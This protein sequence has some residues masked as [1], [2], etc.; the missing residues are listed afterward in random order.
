[1]QRI[2]AMVEPVIQQNVI[3]TFVAGLSDEVLNRSEGDLLTQEMISAYVAQMMQQTEADLQRYLN[4]AENYEG[5]RS[6]LIAEVS[7]IRTNLITMY[8]GL[9]DSLAIYTDTNDTR[10]NNL[11]ADVNRY[12]QLLSDITLDSTN[13]T[14]DNGEIRYGA[15][16]ILSQ[17]RQWDLDILAKLDTFKVSILSTLTTEINEVKNLIRS[18]EETLSILIAELGNTPL[19]KNLDQKLNSSLQNISTL[20]TQSANNAAAQAQALADM[21]AQVTQDTLTRIILVESDL[22]AEVDARANEIGVLEGYITESIA[23]VNTAIADNTAALGTLSTKITQ[24]TQERIAAITSLNDG[25]TSRMELLEQENAATLTALNNY[26]TSNDTALANVSSRIDA[27]V[28]AISGNASRVD[29]LDIRLTSNEGTAATALTK[30]ELALT[31]NTAQASQINSINLALNDKASVSALS[32]LE[33]EVT[34][35]DGRVTINANNITSLSSR[36]TTVEGTL[37]TKADNTALAALT[38]RMSTAEGKISTAA[39]DITQLQ[40][41]VTTINA[42]LETKVSSEAFNSLNSEVDVID[43]KVSSNTAAITSLNNSVNTINSELDNKAEATALNALTN[44]VTSING[45]VTAHS[46]SI[47]ELAGRVTSTEDTLETKADTSLLNSYYTK[48]ETEEVIAGSL[49][50]YKA[51]LVIGGVNQLYNTEGIRTTDGSSYLNYERSEALYNF[52]QDNLGKVIT[53]SFEAQANKAGLLNILASNISAHTFMGMVLIQDPTAW[54][55]YSVSVI[56]KANSNYNWPTLLSTLEFK[57]ITDGMV[58]QLRRVQLEAGTVATAWAPS[59]RDYQNV[60]EDL[61]TTTEANATAIESTNASVAVIN[62]TLTSISTS[63]DALEASLIQVDEKASTSIAN[64]ASAQQTANTA[65]SANAVTSDRVD[66]LEVSYNQVVQD[67]STK[68]SIVAVDAL[69]TRVTA[70]ENGLVSQGTSITQLQDQV[71]T[72]SS[73]VNTKASADA[74]S[75]LTTRVTSIE[76]ENTTQSNNIISLSNSLSTTN[77]NVATA[78]QAATDAMAAAN[79]KGKVIFGNTA[80]IAAERLPQNL[81]I[82][83]TSGTNT[84]KRWDGS[85]WIIVTDKAATDALAAANS[86][87]TQLTTK[88][89]ASALNTLTSSVNAIDTQVT[90]NSASITSLNNSVSSLNSA[91]PNKADSSAVTALTNTVNAQGDTLTAQGN[92]ITSLQ[93]SLTGV[94]NSL[95]T[96]ANAS[97]LSA[98]DTKVTGIE[99]NVSTLSTSLSTLTTEVDDNSATIAVQGSSINGILAEY[100]IKLD[101]NGRVAGVGLVNDGQSAAFGVNADF[102][103]GSAANKPFVVL[104]SGQTINGIA[105]PAGTWINTAFIA[106]ATIG[107]AKIQNASIDTAQIKDAAITSAKIVNVVADKI[108]VPSNVSSIDKLTSSNA[109]YTGTSLTNAAALYDGNW[110]VGSMVCSFGNGNQTFTGPET[111]YLQI[112]LKTAKRIRDINLWWACPDNRRHYYK[113]KVSMD[114]VT[115]GYLAGDSATWV[116]STLPVDLNGSFEKATSLETFNTASGMYFR[117]IRIYGNGN[118]VSTANQL[119]EVGISSENAGTIIDGNNIMTGSIAADRIKVNELSA[120]SANLG[121]MITIA[122]DNSK[123][124]MTGGKTEV[125]YPNGVVAVRL[126]VW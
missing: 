20:Y 57:G 66:N 7:N 70:N 27:N 5:D 22:N 55:R 17:A 122:A 1:M 110:K 52:Y 84:P 15:W 19:I 120:I 25:F 38:T 112:D 114:G 79:A 12:L 106:N 92:S 96:K 90:S 34:D 68:A 23:T 14:L 97:A 111:S 64:A 61:R 78:Q 88:A 31:E 117:Y 48:T 63:I 125:F 59:P 87:L 74:L 101:V 50:E 73:L 86:A 60:I 46:S 100:T 119:Y 104:A 30:A 72:V 28:T 40:S 35:I 77:S 56:V 62:G 118:T 58:P 113:V 76:G 33:A 89:D 54:I 82:D 32:A 102:Y 124:I 21:A 98:L 18:D 99:G 29:A 80:P 95:A 24:E 75:T 94:N 93:T 2:L 85:A 83:T 4:F 53:I 37:T 9:Q 103:V 6:S 13:I 26:K 11:V 107:G 3:D 65:V 123:T 116:L 67:V 115:W 126:G 69:T 49:S 71:T 105:Y 81:W 8:Q 108:M 41:S 47:T 16:T 36:V 44:E 42:A 91:L 39:T 109:V 45:V 43:G 121:T 51:S 10:Y